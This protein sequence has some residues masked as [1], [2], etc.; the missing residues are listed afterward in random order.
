[1]HIS[2]Y[3]TCSGKEEAEK[4]ARALVEE[5]L[6][7]C[8]NYFPINSIYRWKGKVE[9]AEEYA[10]IC[11]TNREKFTKLRKKVKQLH[12]YELPVIL[13]TKFRAEKEVLDWID[14]TTDSI[15]DKYSTEDGK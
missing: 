11:K 15:K 14:E 6:A 1:M 5:K 10:M 8:V 3:I 2:V 12:S 4:I 7:A 13:F 9:T